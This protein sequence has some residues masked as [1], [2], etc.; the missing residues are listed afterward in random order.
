MRIKPALFLSLGVMGLSAGAV[1]AAMAWPWKAAL[2]PLVIGVPVFLLAAAEFCLTALRPES[3]AQAQAVDFVLSRQVSQDL[4]IRRTLV[5]FGWLGGIF[6]LIVA[7]GFPVAL[8]AFVL[9]YL[10]IQA[11]EG[12][13]L[14]LT[15]TAVAGA[16]V[17]GL[18]VRVLHLPFAEGWV[19]TWLGTLGVLG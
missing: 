17:Y 19:Q 13:P 5:T 1:F 14:S 11:G 12:W 6:I 16:F 4:A 2:F 7:L 10:K 15:L 3:P 18:F 9:L 8:P